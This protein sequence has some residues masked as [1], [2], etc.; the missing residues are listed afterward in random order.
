MKL[1][2]PLPLFFEPKAAPPGR[3]WLGWL[4]LLCAWLLCM[5][6]C[7]NVALVLAKGWPLDEA[8]PQAKAPAGCAHAEA[9]AEQAAGS[10]EA[11]AAKLRRAPRCSGA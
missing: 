11:S 6:L 3:W 8:R 10:S 9:I 2:A 7:A 4:Q 5:L 1:N